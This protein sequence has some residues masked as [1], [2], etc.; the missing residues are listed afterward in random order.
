MALTRLELYYCSNR[1]PIT[2]DIPQ[3]LKN[4]FETVDNTPVQIDYKYKKRV[5]LSDTVDV[6]YADL[7]IEDFMSVF[8]PYK[9]ALKKFA[10]KYD[11]IW[12]VA[13]TGSV[14]TGVLPDVYMEN[15]FVQFCS[16]IHAYVTYDISI[17][18]DYHDNFEE[19]DFDDLTYR[20]G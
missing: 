5:F 10:E 6:E 16:A 11:A 8:K 12:N 15:E 17:S 9:F 20:D 4:I 19:P 7:L 1:L 14:D 3:W 2:D 18:K 13:F